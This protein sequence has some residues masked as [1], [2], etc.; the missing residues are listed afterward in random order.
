MPLKDKSY[1]KRLAGKRK[2]AFLQIFSD[3]FYA[4]NGHIHCAYP[5]MMIL[6][7]RVCRPCLSLLTYPPFF[8]LVRG[9]V[10][11]Q[12]H[13]TWLCSP[14]R[15]L[16]FQSSR[17]VLERFDVVRTRKPSMPTAFLRHFAT[18][19]RATWEGPERRSEA[20]GRMGGDV[21]RH[22]SQPAP[23]SPL[24]GKGLKLAEHKE[25]H[26][27]YDEGAGTYNLHKLPSQHWATYN[28]DKVTC[29]VCKRLL[30][31]KKS[32]TDY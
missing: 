19:G 25:I 27:Q 9:P 17:S 23:R 32:I 12:V 6:S 8:A 28:P 7:G 15:P 4:D 5:G 26:Y 14:N 11:W 21:C 29:R 18:E 24:E 3:F 30:K 20:Q 31:S 2:I 13:G 22:V 16:F 1:Q 10:C